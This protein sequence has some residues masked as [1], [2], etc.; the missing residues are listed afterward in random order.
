[1]TKRRRPIPRH[2]ALRSPQGVIAEMDALGLLEKIEDN[3]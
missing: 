1:M 2:D 3:P